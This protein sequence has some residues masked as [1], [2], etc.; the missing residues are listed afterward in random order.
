MS[1][2]F[3]SVIIPVYNDTHSLTRCLSALSNQTYSH[4]SFEVIVVDNHSKEDVRTCVEQFERFLYAYEATPGS[5]AARNK[6]ITI[7]QGKILCFTD[8]DCIPSLDWIEK[9]V[10]KLLEVPHCGL[11]AG[12]VN[13]FFRDPKCPTTAE[14]F[15][16]QTFLNQKQYIEK[17][18]Y[19]AT[20]NVFTL[21]EVFEQVGLFN[22]QL[23]SGGDREWG[24]RVHAAGY[25]QAYSNDV[26]ISHPARHS[27]KALK[28]KVLRVVEG[29]HC[30]DLSEKTTAPALIEFLK[31]AKP[32]LGYAI[33]T[34]TNKEM[35]NF[36][37]K[38]GLIRIHIILR[39]VRAW[40]KLKLHFQ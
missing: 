26:C 14:L 16:S 32:Y 9:G 17:E 24:K 8:A 18:N 37:Y 2:P 40:K 28:T 6:G 12:R 35:P 11:L 30:S 29:Q 27:I 15:D 22:A 33:E 20:A 19:A 4:D 39:Y 3:V 13:F 31:D 36:G 10:S 38:L 34:F 7:A 1:T 23:K 5:Y 21:K 25:R